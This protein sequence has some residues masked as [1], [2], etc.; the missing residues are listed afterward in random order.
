MLRYDGAEV[1]CCS[2][3][4]EG[5]VKDLGPGTYGLSNALLDSPWRK[6][7][8]GREKLQLLMEGE[9]PHSDKHCLTEHLMDILRDDT[10]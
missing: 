4:G 10:W 9:G 8:R 2:N 1:V 3:R 6:V 5:G 7:G